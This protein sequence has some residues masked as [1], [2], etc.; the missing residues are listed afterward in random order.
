MLAATPSYAHS[1]YPYSVYFQTQTCFL[2][3]KV[4]S[5]VD[6]LTTIPH[7]QWIHDYSTPIG[8][9]FYL[10]L[11]K[12][13][14]HLAACP[15]QSELVHVAEQYSVH[16][17]E[18]VYVLQWCLQE[19]NDNRGVQDTGDTATFNWVI[20]KLLVLVASY[21]VHFEFCHDGGRVMSKCTTSSC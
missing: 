11:H 7:N 10:H 13:C 19:Y 17:Q 15:H 8:Y 12:H 20:C 14:R 18:L 2:I 5:T 16:W 21:G 4:Q 9:F 3:L 6:R 1:T